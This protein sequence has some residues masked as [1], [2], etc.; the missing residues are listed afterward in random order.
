LAARLQLTVWFENMLIGSRSLVFALAVL[1]W[2]PVPACADSP[3]DDQ[4]SNHRL[5]E[6]WK[7]D[8]EHYTRLRYDLSTFL[9]LPVERQAQ[10]RE[11]D[12]ALHE[13]NS[14]TYARLRRTLERYHE[15]LRTLPQA[16]RQK[17]DSLPTSHERLLFIKQLREQE[18]ISRLP[19]TVQDELRN[20]PADKQPARIAE[21][22]REDRAR[23]EQWRYAMRH[24]DELTRPPPMRLK[25][26]PEPVQTFVIQSLRP[27]LSPEEKERL[28]KAEGHWPQFAQTLVELN[29]K[30]PI[31]LPGPTTGPTRYTELPDDIQLKVSWLLKKPE[32]GL[33]EWVEKVE[34]K[35]TDYAM[36]VAQVAD[37]QHIVLPYQL[38]PCRPSEF[39]PMVQQFIEK[40]LLP[41]L[42]PQELKDL[43]E[44]EGR[45]P[46]YAITLRDLSRK[47]KLQVP[48][49]VLPGPRAQWDRFRTH[50][51]ASNSTLPE[52]ADHVLRD[53]M[54][55]ELSPEE[56][57][58]LSSLSLADPASREQIK[59]AYFR[60]HPQALTRM[61]QADKDKNAAKK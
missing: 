25:D 57:A 15:W 59:Q 41:V 11:L 47:H 58:N 1:A 8:P 39:S 2:L 32:R 4:E 3:G 34:G 5:L 42:G 6:K 19:K 31:K 10:L 28:D 24:W 50:P 33:L 46:K 37:K 35:W 21:L 22:R 55:N 44:A 49:M 23:R 48:G 60:R 17:L 9:A 40:R 14:A 61:I 52:V 29:D 18:W 45:W 16:E 53:F 43:K 54:Q 38:G 7:A 36:L 13:E 12:R 20:L 51:S 56:Q 27:M 26:F 30:H